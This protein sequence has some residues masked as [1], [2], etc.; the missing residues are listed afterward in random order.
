VAEQDDDVQ[1]CV[2]GCGADGVLWNGRR[3]LSAELA[4]RERAG[5]RMR[6]C[7]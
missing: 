7:R 3:E 6:K 4:V 1:A 5:T 2:C